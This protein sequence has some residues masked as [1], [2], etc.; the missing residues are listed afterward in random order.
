M[1][2]TGKSPLL[3]WAENLK[4]IVHVNS[5]FSHHEGERYEFIYAYSW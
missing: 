1:V 4:E 3:V 5:C 2:E